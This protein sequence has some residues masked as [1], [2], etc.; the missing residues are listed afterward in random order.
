MLGSVAASLRPTGFTSRNLRTWHSI[1]VTTSNIDGTSFVRDSMICHPLVGHPCVPPVAA[2]HRPARDQD[3]WSD[4]DIRPGGFPRN[5]DP[6]GERRSGSLG[7][8]RAAVL[9][10]MLVLCLGEVVHPI[11]LSPVK[12]WG[13]GTLWHSSLDLTWSGPRMRDVAK[14]E[15]RVGIGRGKDDGEEREEEPR[16]S[17]PPS[18]SC[19][20]SQLK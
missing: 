5:L 12:S 14:V 9:R 6:V 18:H 4:V 19:R 20:V 17:H 1:V 7:P 16:G 10:D 11:H 15:A 2:V 13:R 8:T 3:L